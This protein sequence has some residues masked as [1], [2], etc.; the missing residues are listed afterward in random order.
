MITAIIASW[1]VS[2][3]EIAL[4]P[5]NFTQAATSAAVTVSASVTATISCAVSTTTTD[6]G[7]LTSASIST[8]SPNAST[9]MSC[10]N[11]SAGCTLSVKNNGG[12][13]NSGLWNSVSSYLI[14]SPASGYPATSTL[15][16]G[17]EGYGIQGATTTAGSGATLGA[18]TRYLQTGNV[19]G[20]LLIAGTTLASSSATT[21][22]REMIV[23]HK[24][25]IS[26]GTSGGSYT[27]TITYSCT[28]N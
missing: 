22:A 1:F 28:A 6:F 20:G 26:T 9:S 4:Q 25:A 11:S 10:A 24:A 8:A 16:A 17:T 3:S 27:D 5:A 12:G 23:T 18:A 2:V 14:P 19:V 13:G 15:A 7:T 21:S